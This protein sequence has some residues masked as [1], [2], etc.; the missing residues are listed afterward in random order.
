LK[1]SHVE[2]TGFTAGKSLGLEPTVFESSDVE[3]TG[4]TADKS[5]ESETCYSTA[6]QQKYE[7]QSQVLTDL[8]T[9]N[10]SSLA[11]TTPHADRPLA[12]TF[13]DG[14]TVIGQ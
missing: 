7:L 11:D 10:S 1:A 9:A 12:N 6:S 14:S 3:S 13:L 5:P 2:S 4:F 8:K